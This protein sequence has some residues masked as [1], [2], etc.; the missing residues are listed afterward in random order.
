MAATKKVNY[1][2]LKQEA[3]QSTTEQ[4]D[5]IF[6]AINSL[7]SSSVSVSSKSS[8][9]YEE[10]DDTPIIRRASKKT[11]IQKKEKKG[12]GG[13]V[14]L[15]IPDNLKTKWKVFCT[16]HGVSLTDSIKLGMKLLMEMEDQKMITIEDGVITM[17][18]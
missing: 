12:N 16:E 1:E 13:Y 2:N 17:N 10:T 4:V 15:V 6:N 11:E 8:A 3:D 18:M 5:D 14:S 9:S 7:G